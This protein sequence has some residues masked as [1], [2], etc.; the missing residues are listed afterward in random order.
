MRLLDVNISNFGAFGEGVKVDFTRYD[1]ADK[2]L[3]IGENNDAAGA[4]SNGA[5]KSTL[6]NAISWGVFGRTPNDVSAGDVIRRGMGSCEVNLRLLDEEDNEIIINRKRQK[7]GG[8]EIKWFLNGESKT[9][10]TLN[11]TQKTLLNY[12]GILENNTEYYNDFLNTTYFSIEAVKAFAGKRSS[13]RDRMSLIARFLNLEILDKCLSKAKVYKNNVTASLKTVQGQVEFVSNKLDQGFNLVQ[14]QS[15]TEEAKVKIKQYQVEN[16]KLEKQVEVLEQLSD[17]IERLE[18]IKFNLNKAKDDHETISKV[19]EEQINDL[20]DK[21]QNQAKIKQDIE[22]Q[23]NI[24]IEESAL[25]KDKNINK[26]E[27][28]LSQANIKIAQS[29][30]KQESLQKQL[31]NHLS[32]PG[33]KQELMVEENNLTLFHKA[34][35]QASIEKLK[36]RRG[37]REKLVKT[38]K[39]EYKELTALIAANAE[40]ELK[41]KY[42]YKQLANTAE[43]PDK[44]KRIKLQIKDQNSKSLAYSKSLEKNKLSIELKIRKYQQYDVEIIQDVKNTIEINQK[45]IEES[46]DSIA[47][48]KTMIES[49]YSDKE[50]L[51]LMVTKENELLGEVSNYH[52]WVEGFP[53]I[54]RWMIESFLPSFEEQTNSFLNNLEVGMR[55]RFDTLKEKKSKQNEF[56]EEFDLSIIDENNEKRDLETYSQG[57]SKRIGVCVGFALRE[58]TLNK[59]YSNFNFLLMDEVIDSLDETGIGEFMNLLNNITGMKL[60]ITHNSDLKSRFGNVIRVTKTEGIS[61]IIQS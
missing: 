51:D 43:I 47:R 15:D 40:R 44:I 23:E 16:K 9:Q 1:P 20:E 6:L 8:H 55:V 49:Y 45:N 28:W 24:L 2:V 17:F 32:C 38:K 3:I 61:D 60:L 46:R 19:Y 26:Y 11:Q 30:E 21:L 35:I 50:Q 57:E 12:F 37:E 7:K 34:T 56:K 29:I 52:F 10:R 27:Q 22:E 33:C 36:D 42:L 41:V 18:D 31:D 53:S 5:G 48:N 4:D 54:R 14:L 39:A 58:L 25:L 59:G 13:S